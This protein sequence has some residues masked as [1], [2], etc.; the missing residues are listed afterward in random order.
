MYSIDVF[1]PLFSHIEHLLLAAA[2]GK[3]C[4][5]EAAAADCARLIRRIRSETDLRQAGSDAW[6]PVQAW[7][8]EKLPLLPFGPGVL[9][10]LP[11]LPENALD[12]FT[13]RL[14]NLF[15]KSSSGTASE[16]EKDLLRVYLACFELGTG[17]RRDKRPGEERAAYARQCRTSLDAAPPGARKK[18]R[19]ARSRFP[20]RAAALAMPPAAVA[21]LYC[22]YRICLNSLLQT[23]L[24]G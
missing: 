17:S 6:F 12:I 15:L 10:T 21:G 4:P 18:Q 11:P 2:H 5:R 3:G 7:L 24:G 8:S 23:V 22:V 13:L 19:G 14:D 20:A 16:E 1:L 9:E